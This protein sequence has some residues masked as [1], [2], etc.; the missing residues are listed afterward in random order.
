MDPPV[1]DA[2]ETESL[3]TIYQ[4]RVQLGVHLVFGR[5]AKKLDA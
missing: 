3:A 4:S 5:D 1:S 2:K